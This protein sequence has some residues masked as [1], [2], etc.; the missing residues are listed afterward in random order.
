MPFIGPL[1]N[2]ILGSP[3]YQLIDFFLPCLEKRKKLCKEIKKRYLSWLLEIQG[4]FFHSKVLLE[5]ALNFVVCSVNNDL[6]LETRSQASG[7]EA[8]SMAVTDLPPFH[9]QIPATPS[10]LPFTPATVGPLFLQQVKEAR[11]QG[12]CTCGSC[13]WKCSASGCLPTLASL[14]SLLHAT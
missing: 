2:R 4:D 1:G 14:R 7:S 13:C 8:L 5:K 12:L 11:W 6:A 9:L 3:L 10:C